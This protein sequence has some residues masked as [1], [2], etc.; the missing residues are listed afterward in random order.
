MS[1]GVGTEAS[2]GL[3]WVAFGLAVATGILAIGA[4]PAEA[5]S[6]RKRYVYNPPYASIV[7]DANSGAVLQ[8]TNADSRRHPASLTKIMTLYLLFERLESGRLNLNTRLPVSAHAAAQAPTKLGLRPGQTI[9]V[10]DAILALVTKSANDAAVVIAEAIGGTES[11]FGRMMTRKARVL[12]MQRTTYTNA[13]GLPDSDQITTARDQALLGRAVQERFP[14]YYRYFATKAFEYKGRS[15]RNHNRLLG[16]VKG[17]DGIKT[18]YTRA[19]G[20]NLTTSMHHGG[21]HVVAVVLGGRS[22]GQRDARMRDLLSD[23]VMTASTRRTAPAIAE[24]PDATEDRRVAAVDEPVPMP[25]SNPLVLDQVA[26]ADAIAMVQ[27][28]PAATAYAPIADPKPGST[29]PIKPLLVKTLS[30]RPAS[31]TAKAAKLAFAAVRLSDASKS[32]PHAAEEAAPA[33]AASEKPVRNG[34]M[35]Q[36]GAFDEEKEA[37]MRLNSVQSRAKKVLGH[38]DP[39]TESVTKGEKTLYRARF[40]G[41]DKHQAETA[42]RTLKR[43]DIACLALKN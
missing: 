32:A 9:E 40:A 28:I 8:A 27:T 20:F 26:A 16:R 34:W 38:A 37:R 33:K 41:L 12:G 18:G 17:V 10:E 6:K 43:S 3:R 19:S 14:R 22:S 31:R 24:A 36:V 15:M 5:R 35:I 1:V 7:I 39:F 25:V 13:S 29:D 21:R 23:H 4:D 30:I 11:G 42:C 2:R